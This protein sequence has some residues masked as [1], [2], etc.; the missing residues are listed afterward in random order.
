M[1]RYQKI[2]KIDERL[3]GFPW[4]PVLVEKVLI[5]IHQAKV[6][7]VMGHELGC[8]ALC[9][10]VGEMLAVFRFQ[11]SEYARTHGTT[12]R[13]TSGR[14]KVRNF[15]EQ[16]QTQRM[17]LLKELGLI[18]S[19][20][21]DKLA[22]LARTRNKW[23]HRLSETHEALSDDAIE[24]YRLACEL[25]EAFFR[26]GGEGERFNLNPDVLAYLKGANANASS[27]T[28]ENEFQSP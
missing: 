20:T 9:G 5:P 11:I 8:I 22:K 13:V 27:R 14:R 4:E 26:S 18:D 7:F 19:E 2:E 12:N 3:E 25:A 28:R 17:G 16:T 1:G 24:S 21:K 10:M 6:A 23:L 15:E